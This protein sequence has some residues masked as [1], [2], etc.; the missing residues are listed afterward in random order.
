MRRDPGTPV[1]RRDQ[2][3]VPAAL[4]RSE[5]ERGDVDAQAVRQRSDEAVGAR[6]R[7]TG[8]EPPGG[9]DGNRLTKLS[10]PTPRPEVARGGAIDRPGIILKGSL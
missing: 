9:S 6:T 3:G 1:H 10:S 5:H 8:A 2:R 4:R 7:R